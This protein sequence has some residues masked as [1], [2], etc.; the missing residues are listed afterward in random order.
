ME[1]T[2]ESILVKVFR[3]QRRII[4]GGKANLKKIET[5]LCIRNVILKK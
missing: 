3:A 4:S 5:L 2:N 1:D